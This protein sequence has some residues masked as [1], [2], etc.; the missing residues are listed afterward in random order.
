MKITMPKLRIIHPKYYQA[1][2]EDIIKIYLKLSFAASI[3]G[4]VKIYELIKLYIISL[5]G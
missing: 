1:V 4:W 5:K 3:Y 2:A